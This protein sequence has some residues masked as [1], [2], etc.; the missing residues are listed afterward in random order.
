M[1]QPTKPS[2]IFNGKVIKTGLTFGDK[3]RIFAGCLVLSACIVS[4]IILLAEF[5][6][7]VLW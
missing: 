1:N 4:G 3:I 5:I 7:R 6:V 2:F